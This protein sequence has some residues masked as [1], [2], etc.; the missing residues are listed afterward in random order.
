MYEGK[1]SVAG[2]V[3]LVTTLEVVLKSV[4]IVFL[5]VSGHCTTFA[6]SML[7]VSVL[8]S[9]SQGVYSRVYSLAVH[10]S[11]FSVRLP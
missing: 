7:C 11:K 9:S 10:A 4:R 5:T 2:I 1:L 8:L 6:Y 3:V